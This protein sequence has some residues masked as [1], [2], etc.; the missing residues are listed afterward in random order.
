V[1]ECRAVLQTQLHT[2]DL[3]VSADCR[4]LYAG[5]VDGRIRVWDIGFAVDPRSDQEDGDDDDAL[6]RG[7]DLD[8]PGT[9]VGSLDGKIY[10]L[11][12][13]HDPLSGEET[14][15]A[16]GTS[17]DVCVFR[18]RGATNSNTAEDLD[19]NCAEQLASIVGEGTIWSLT[20]ADRR[21]TPLLLSGGGDGSIQ[22]FD[23]RTFAAVGALKQQRKVTGLATTDV[24]CCSADQL[25]INVWS[26]E[27]WELVHCISQAHAWEIWC[28]RIDAAAGYL[29]SSAF[30]H[31]IKVFDIGD[32]AMLSKAS[33]SQSQSAGC[34]PVGPR[35]RCVTT[36]RGHKGYVHSVALAAN[37]VFSAS[38]DRT[39]RVWSGSR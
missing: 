5:G 24:L 9:E 4:R 2:W 8:L 30:D 23:A 31:T 12:L 28:L 35:F 32:P 29:F 20:M 7:A 11:V 39:I 18:L 25:D 22:A 16:A 37:H 1:F 14:L 15:F 38:A 10:G 19:C 27:T 34:S 26:M 33:Q 6:K 36:L 21:A 13:W 17:G 3:A